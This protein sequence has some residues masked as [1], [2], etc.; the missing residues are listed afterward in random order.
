MTNLINLFKERLAQRRQYARLIAEIES[1][2]A[3]DLQELRADPIEMRRQA[4]IS[5]YGETRA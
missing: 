4:W 1:L 3:R 2:N 5:V